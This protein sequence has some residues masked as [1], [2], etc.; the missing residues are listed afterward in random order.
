MPDR[1]V[2]SSMRQGSVH[3]ANFTYHRWLFTNTHR[4]RLLLEIADTSDTHVTTRVLED[5]SYISHYLR[6]QSTRIDLRPIDA[7][8]TEISLT[9]HYERRL[10]P[11]WYFGPLQ[12]YRRRTHGRTI[13]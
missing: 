8:T 4:G 11:A 2:P 5:T 3:K 1:V 10:D 6:L 7:D 13:D 12:R 9:V